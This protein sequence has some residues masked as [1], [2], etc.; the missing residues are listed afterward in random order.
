M[1]QESKN[2]KLF[3]IGIPSA[4]LD[5]ETKRL[6]EHIMPGAIILFARNIVSPQQIKKLVDDIN[7][8]LGYKPLISID[9]EGGIVSRLREGFSVSPGSMALTAVNDPDCIYDVSKILAREMKAIGINWNL[10]PVVDINCNPKNPG[11]GVRSYSDSIDKVIENSKQFVNAMHEEGVMT[12]LK[13]FPG[14]GR[15]SV[16]AHIDLPIL[17]ISEKELMEFELRPFRELACESIMPSHIYIPS[18]QRVKEPASLSYEVLTVLARQ[19]LGYKGVLVSDDL[20]MG[21]V[22]N[23]YSPEQAMIMSLKAGMDVLTFCH[24]PLVQIRVYNYLCS[25]VQKDETVYE[26][27]SESFTRI[28]KLTEKANDFP[29]QEYSI[30]DIGSKKSLELIQKIT[31]RSVTS[32]ISDESIL[33]LKSDDVG[34][35]FSVRLTRQVQVEDGPNDGIP[36]VARKIA[37]LV[38]KEICVI[39]PEV[40]IDEIKDLLKDVNCS[41]VNIFFTE[42]AHLKMGQR[43][44]VEELCKI[45]PKSLIIALRNPYDCFIKGVRNSLLTYGYELVSQNSLLKVLKGQIKPCGKISVKEYNSDEV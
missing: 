29:N 28:E 5:D 15:V 14:K 16:D 19:K 24:D 13:H 45:S 34:K 9:Q 6:L 7:A 4:V 2:G 39:D 42:N 23:Y 41:K 17:D 35:V 36:M 31:D 22:S 10:A 32:R 21:G 44:L 37:Q 25:M 43:K 8:F 33:P 38:K 1:M 30:S 27:V 12:C 20:S 3:M 18:I 40:K 11:I 26:R